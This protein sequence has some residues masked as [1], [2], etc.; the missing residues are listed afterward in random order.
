LVLL[1]EDLMERTLILLKPDAV[2]R[3]L[4]GAIISRFEAK[5]LKIAGAKLMRIT[6]DLAE[7]HYAPHKGKDFY[8]PL[9]A[10][11]TS[12]PAVAMVLEGNDA[13]R[14]V[15]SMMGPTFGPDAP[16]G[17]IRGDWGMSKRY[18]LVHGSDSL[19]TAAREIAL[20]FRPEGLLSYDRAAD[21][22]VYARGDAGLI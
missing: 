8:E 2:Q 13:V 12:G 18:N 5:G 7:R 6:R 21:E 14:V 1:N 15:R 4:V 20:F 3:G 11:I 22:W 19:E 10:F 17:T 16:A 9:L